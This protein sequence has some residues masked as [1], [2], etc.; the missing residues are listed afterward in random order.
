[1]NQF[2]FLK[3][4]DWDTH[5]LIKNLIIKE[6]QGPENFVQ[7]NV[8]GFPNTQSLMMISVMGIQ[9]QPDVFWSGLP[10]CVLW[11][12]VFIFFSRSFFSHSFLPL[13]GCSYSTLPTMWKSPSSPDPLSPNSFGSKSNRW[14][15]DRR[16]AARSPNALARSLPP[17]LLL[18]PDHPQDNLR[19]P[20]RHHPGV[21]AQSGPRRHREPERRQTGQKHLLPVQDSPQQLPRGLRRLPAPGKVSPSEILG[22]GWGDFI[23]IPRAQHRTVV[24]P[25]W[26]FS[27]FFTFDRLQ[28]PPGD[29][30]QS[31]NLMAFCTFVQTIDELHRMTNRATETRI[32]F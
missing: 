30:C 20:S 21:E 8:K 19:E 32:K 3:E 24:I 17:A 6:V 13:V 12:I 2:C 18:L 28:S 23:F 14:V 7:K 27:H 11:K 25:Q 22:E 26:E 5:T 31:Q 29:E 15:S 4:I 9:D 10:L 16:P 1:M